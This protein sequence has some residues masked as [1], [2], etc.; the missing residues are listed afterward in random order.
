[1]GLGAP[2]RPH[3]EVVT[4]T[5]RLGTRGSA[6]ARVQAELVRAALGRRRPKI[7]V[8]VVPIVTQGDRVQD[9]ATD[10][11]FTDAID[12]ALVAGEV[13]LAVHSAKDLPAVASRGVRLAA[14]L[15]RADPRDAL[16]LRTRGTLASLPPGTR[17][18]SSS[19]R[20]RA[21]LRRA[22][23]D[24]ELVE[25]RGNVDTRLARVQSGEIDGAVLAVAGLR[26]LGRADAV[27]E[28]LSVARFLPAPGQ[29]AIAVAVRASDRALGRKVAELDDPRSRAAVTAERSF[30]E[31]VGGDCDTPL[32]AVA[33]VRAG[34]L[35]LRAELLSANG[36]RTVA[37]AR[38]GAPNSARAIGL[39]LATGVLRAG[40]RTLLHEARG[41]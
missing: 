31:G 14:F 21:Q 11:D 10:L 25:L 9:R 41:G 29:G 26:R 2:Q 30:V 8:R 37:G 38:R 35:W 36:Q 16:V 17:L 34:R 22:R 20:R 19:P 27:T 1:M 23:P 28:V 3:A 12:R 32:G 7:D 6:L 15:P 39:G 13:D 5:I 18:G 40:G 33:T 4:E 24:L